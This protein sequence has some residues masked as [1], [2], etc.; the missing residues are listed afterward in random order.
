ML[1]ARFDDSGLPGL[2]P[3]VVTVDLR[4]HTPEEF[5]DLVVVKLANEDMNA[6]LPSKGTA[7]RG[8]SAGSG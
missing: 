6:A 8:S 4:R 2:L 7:A 5:A 1:P 3:D